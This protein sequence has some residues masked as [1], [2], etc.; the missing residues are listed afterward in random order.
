MFHK[1]QLN[2]NQGKGDIDFVESWVSLIFRFDP[3]A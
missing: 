1:T 2:Q 3:V